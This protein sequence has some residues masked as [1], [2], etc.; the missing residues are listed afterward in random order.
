M[1]RAAAA[2]CVLLCASALA[3]T[4]APETSSSTSPPLIPLDHFTRYDEF[5]TIEI[6]PDGKF[7]AFTSGRFGT[8]QLSFI[9][10][11]PLKGVAGVKAVEGFEFYDFH[12]VSDERV[13]HLLAER[14]AGNAFRPSRARSP[15]SI[16]TASV[17][18]RSREPPAPGSIR[19][20]CGRQVLRVDRAR[21]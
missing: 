12:W 2:A 5:G 13:I 14:Q 18:P 1:H 3:D 6:S 15:R 20:R 11:D 17:T 19:A 16:A 4:P 8:T 9:Q 7:L 21:R 10:L